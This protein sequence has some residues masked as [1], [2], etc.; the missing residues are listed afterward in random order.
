MSCQAHCVG[1]C[2][3][4]DMNIRKENFAAA[5]LQSCVVA[6]S[7]VSAQSLKCL[8]QDLQNLLQFEAVEYEP[9]AS[10]CV[11]LLGLYSTERHFKSRSMPE[12]MNSNNAGL[13]Q[14][15]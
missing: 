3:Q 9:P 13:M 8:L 7:K 10:F 11:H 15:L 12:C 6:C 1:E 5:S 4:L 14:C 2:V